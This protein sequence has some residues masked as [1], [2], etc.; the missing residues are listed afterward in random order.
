MI[1]SPFLLE[2]FSFPCIAVDEL[3]HQTLNV[4]QTLKLNSEQ[5]LLSLHVISGLLL[6]FQ[7]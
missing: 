3:F 2:T 5:S 1:S 6:L 4:S 7:P